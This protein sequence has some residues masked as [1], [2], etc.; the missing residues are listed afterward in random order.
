MARSSLWVLL[1]KFILATLIII[2]GSLLVL[3]RSTGCVAGGGLRIS[4]VGWPVLGH[5]GK[6]KR[7]LRVEFVLFIRVLDVTSGAP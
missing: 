1:G 5:R 6:C 4:Y 3:G 2:L 7:F